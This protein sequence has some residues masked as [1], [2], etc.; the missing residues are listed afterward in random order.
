M[1]ENT[2]SSNRISSLG[3]TTSC[4]AELFSCTF[5][6]P[7]GHRAGWRPL[8]VPA[9]GS[10]SKKRTSAC[11]SRPTPA[12]PVL[13]N[14]TR[15]SILSLMPREPQASGTVTSDTERLYLSIASVLQTPGMTAFRLWLRAAITPEGDSGARRFGSPGHRLSRVVPSP[16]QT[17]TEYWHAS[18]ILRSISSAVC[19]SERGVVEGFIQTLILLARGRT[20]RSPCR[21]PEVAAVG[22]AGS[23][24]QWDHGDLSR[25]FTKGTP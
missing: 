7:N 5:P 14:S 9:A 15:R 12:T 23:R 25:R 16:R 6:S 4:I 8:S 21:S 24:S 11:S 19:C 10:S 13:S 22:L 1:Y 17:S 18:R 20:R 2:T 3:P